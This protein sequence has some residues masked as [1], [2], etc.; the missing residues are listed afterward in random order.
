MINNLLPGHTRLY[1]EFGTQFSFYGG[2]STQMVLPT[3]TPVQ[4]RE[5]TLD[6]M[7]NLAPDGT[8][9]ILGPSHRMQSDI[10]EENVAAMLEAFPPDA[11]NR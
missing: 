10:P 7:R 5:A 2:I 8:G 4:V 9:L 11:L 6:C 1:R 3:G